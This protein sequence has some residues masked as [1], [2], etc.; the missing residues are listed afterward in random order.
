MF[1]AHSELL[2]DFWEHG[3]SARCPII[4]FHAHM[5]PH[6]GSFMPLVT[7]EKMV[8]KMQRCGTRLTIFSGHDAMFVPAFHHAHDLEAVGKF[9]QQLRAYFVMNGSVPDQQSELELLKS[10]PDVFV[11]LKTLGDYFGYRVNDPVYTPYYDYADEH[12]MPVLLHTWGGSPYNGVS[13]VEKLAQRYR[14][15]T[16][17]V[18]HSCH[19][20]WEE[21]ARLANTYANVYL[22][23]TAVFDEVGPLE[24]LLS[25]CSS[26]KI[27]FGTDLPWFDTM[28]GVGY[29]FST[30]MTDRDR[31]NILF[32][33]GVRILKK[34]EWFRQLWN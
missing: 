7:A 32:R 14:R 12:E 24:I 9:P 27:V 18:G 29:L 19:G 17:I 8:A 34:H 23:L 33:N 26:E 20:E 3:R 30:P 22:E 1:N 4:D 11:G 28:H 25:K 15:L 10:R 6:V 2:K 5:N 16:I 13:E 21:A 31:E